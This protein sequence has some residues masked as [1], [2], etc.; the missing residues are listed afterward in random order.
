VSCK[1]GACLE[2]ITV[3]EDVFPGSPESAAF[4]AAL[5][6]VRAVEPGVADAIGAELASQREQLKLIASENYASPAVLLAMGN[7]LSDKYAEG[8]PGRRMYAGCEVLDRIETLA[9]EHARALFGAE[10]GHARPPCRK[11]FPR[12]SERH[13]R[14]RPRPRGVGATAS[15]PRR[16]APARHDP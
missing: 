2:K 9:A 6:V 7:W 4:R 13:S 15:S 11:A 8:V 3:G 16:S 12:A 10:F 5:E 14:E 1:T